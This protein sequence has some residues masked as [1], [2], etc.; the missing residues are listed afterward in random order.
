MYRVN[1]NVVPSAFPLTGAV[2]PRGEVT[3]RSR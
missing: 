3:V 1:G 2:E